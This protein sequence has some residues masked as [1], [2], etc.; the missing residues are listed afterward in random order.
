MKVC[1]LVALLLVASASAFAPPPSANSKLAT[2]AVQSTTALG[3][4]SGM[5]PDEL[6]IVL[7]GLR[8]SYGEQSR[9]YRRSFFSHDEWLKHRSADRFPGT[10]FK[11]VKSGVVRVLA[12][13]VFF[14]TMTATFVVVWNAFL[15]AGYVGFDSIQHDPIVSHPLP[16]LAMPVTPFTFS[17]PALALLLGT[18]NVKVACYSTSSS[19][20][21]FLTLSFAH[22]V[23]F[24]NE[25]RLPTLGRGSKGVGGYCEPLP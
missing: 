9:K 11:L 1:A 13:E 23:S 15:S 8:N 14:I 3:P 21:L 5:S 10:L 24:Q 16:L 20:L 22:P 18:S 12:P 4:L 7:E 25:C 6:E 19:F 17:S 2:P